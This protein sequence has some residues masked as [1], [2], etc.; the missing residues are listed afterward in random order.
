MDAL[1]AKFQEMSND[2]DTMTLLLG[3]CFFAM[4]F[5][6][7]QDIRNRYFEF[8]KSTTVEK[9][10][11]DD[12]KEVEPTGAS[13]SVKK[14]GADS[15]APKP[16]AFA[17][18]DTP[19]P[20]P[21]LSRTFTLEEL[22]K[23]DGSDAEKPIYVAIKGI[24]FDVSAKKAMYGPEGGYRCFAGRD[25]SKALGLSSLKVEDCIADYSSLNEKELKTLADWYSFFEKRYAIVG[26]T[27]A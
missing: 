19:L 11:E 23:F 2:R 5:S 25:A 26:K 10:E 15:S 9:K 17:V 4:V 20:A 14:S 3:A 13:S 27:K 8:K 6:I 24:V 18:P 16:K 12:Q 21:N 22:S 1:K 7:L